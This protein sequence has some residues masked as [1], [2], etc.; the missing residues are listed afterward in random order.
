MRNMERRVM[1]GLAVMG[2]ALG[3]I[4]PALVPAESA[5]M[6]NEYGNVVVSRGSSSNGGEACYVDGAVHGC[7]TP[8]PMTLYPQS[9]KV[10]PAGQPL[11][12]G[13]DN[14]PARPF[15]GGHEG[16]K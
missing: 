15:D 4:T 1:R 7:D 3:L 6:V 8:A 14:Q 13:S 2:L 11:F 9:D 5:Q 16:E 12:G 10:R